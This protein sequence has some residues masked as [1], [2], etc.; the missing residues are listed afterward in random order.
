MHTHPGLHAREP[1]RQRNTRVLQG[2]ETLWSWF[3]QAVGLLKTIG[4]FATKSLGK[5]AA[6]QQ[7]PQNCKDLSTV[8]KRFWEE[9]S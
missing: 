7:L 5:P 6:H 1:G 3:S 2:I 8:L 4:Y 9:F